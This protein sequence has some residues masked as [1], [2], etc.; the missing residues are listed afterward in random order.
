MQA[1]PERSQ[2][3]PGRQ[4]AWFVAPR[5]PD[6]ENNSANNDDSNGGKASAT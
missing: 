6:S 5:C 2:I 1:L 3:E 4:Q